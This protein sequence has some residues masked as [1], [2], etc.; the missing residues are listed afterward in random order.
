MTSQGAVEGR[1]SNID[2]EEVARKKREENSGMKTKFRK[3]QWL[4]IP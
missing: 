1:G 3:V 2:F 4:Q